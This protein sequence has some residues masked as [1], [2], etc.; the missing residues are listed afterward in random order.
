MLGTIGGTE[1]P[2]RS[3][4]LPGAWTPLARSEAVG[5]ASTTAVCH[6]DRPYYVKGQCFTCYNRDYRRRERAA[7][8]VVCASCGGVRPDGTTTAWLRGGVCKSCRDAIQCAHG[9]APRDKRCSVC[10][11]AKRQRATCHPDRDN[12]GG[13][14]CPSCYAKAVPAEVRRERGRAYYDK[15][16]EKRRAYARVHMRDYYARNPEKRLASTARRQERIDANGRFVVTER[17]IRRLW[18]RFDGRCAYCGA[19]AREAD[20]VVPVSRGGRH[21]IGNLVPAC[22]SCNSSKQRRLIVE[23]RKRQRAAA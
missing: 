6:P 4:Q 5:K 21:S 17:D 16:V 8:P 12:Y 23:W 11:R 2:P 20:H 22:R 9:V 1:T 19:K 13:G 18:V 3:G 14:L 7:Q 10:V 15:H